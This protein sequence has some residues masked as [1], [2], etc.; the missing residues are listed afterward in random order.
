MNDCSW[1]YRVSPKGL[2]KMDYYN[3]VKVC[4]NYALSYPKPISEGD[5]DVHVRGVKI[6]YFS[7]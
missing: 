3:R 2:P 7:I 1:M 5:I 6:T 4:I